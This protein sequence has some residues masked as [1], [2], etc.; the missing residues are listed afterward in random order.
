M[1]SIGEGSAEPQ[2]ESV[3]LMHRCEQLLR[4]YQT[5]S[6]E[7]V[8]GTEHNLDYP[9]PHG[10]LRR[11]LNNLMVSPACRTIS[12][13]VELVRQAEAGNPDARE[14]LREICAQITP[15][16]FAEILRAQRESRE[17]ESVCPFLADTRPLLTLIQT[18]SLDD[19][20]A[21]FVDFIHVLT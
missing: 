17:W 12:R 14:R 20:V 4:D 9:T 16:C 2:R 18:E 21:F 15:D 1:V 10:R 6:L 11:H 5:Y 7:Y 19:P 13:R 3:P 8:L